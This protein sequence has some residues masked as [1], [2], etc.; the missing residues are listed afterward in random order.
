V[1]IGQIPQ[2]RLVVN[3]WVFALNLNEHQWKFSAWPAGEVCPSWM[4]MGSI[5]GVCHKA[6]KKAAIFLVLRSPV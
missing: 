3:L 5:A 2:I 6:Q 4:K 1:L